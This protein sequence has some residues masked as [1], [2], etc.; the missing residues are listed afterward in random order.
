M[1]DQLGH[2]SNP[3]GYRGKYP[4]KI[5]SV[6]SLSGQR[7]VMRVTTNAGERFDI[8]GRDTGGMMPRPGEDIGNHPYAARVGGPN[9]SDAASQL[10]S[11]AKS[12]TVPVHD[13]MIHG[14]KS[15]VEPSVAAHFVRERAAA[16][17]F[18]SGKREINRLRKQGK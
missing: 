14:G 2:G 4:N 1:K 3:R 12:E 9:N 15:W 11:G 10:A 6:G 17:G 5:Q 7:G 16:K 18:R 8:H 13:G